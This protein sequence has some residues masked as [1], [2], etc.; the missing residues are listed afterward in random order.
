MEAW[1]SHSFIVTTSLVNNC[2][3][4]SV[5]CS[6]CNGLPITRWRWNIGSP[7]DDEWCDATWQCPIVAAI[8]LFHRRY[9]LQLTQFR[10]S[11]GECCN[12]DSA[13]CQYCL[14]GFFF[15]VICQVFYQIKFTLGIDYTSD[16]S[17]LF[18]HVTEVLLS[19]FSFLCGRSCY[20]SVHLNT[21][22]IL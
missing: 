20:L 12:R 10:V 14:A 1:Y 13:L 15:Q 3:F 7:I 5:F 16:T 18:Y 6:L 8:L 9:D 17:P 19:T 2:P 21:Q 11:L 4:N 22:W